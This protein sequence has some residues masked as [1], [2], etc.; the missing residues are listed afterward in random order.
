MTSRVVVA[1]AVSTLALPSV[2]GAALKDEQALAL[3]YAPAVELVAQAH[4]CG[5]GESYE[6]IDVD[7]LFDEPTV[8]L[9]GPWGGSDLVKIAPAASDLTGAR[10]EYHLDFPGNALHPGCDYERWARLITAGSSP[11]VYAHVA[12]DVHDPGKLALQYWFYYVFNDWNNTHEGDWEM[13]QLDFDAAT[14]HDALAV[15]PASVGYSQHEG[16]ERAAWDDPKLE[17]VGGTHPVVHPAAGSHANFYGEALYLGSSASE[18]VGC[19]DTRGPTFNIVPVVKTIPNDPAAAEKEFPWIAF[20]GRWGELQ[21][22]FFN[23]PTGPNLKEQWTEPFRWSA[24]WRDRSIAVPGGGAF[25]TGATDFFCSAVGAGSNGLRRSL[26]HPLPALLILAVLIALAV[27]VFTRTTWRPA[28]PLR[29]ARRRAWGQVLAA[30]ARMYAGRLW[31]FLG[32]GVLAVPISVAVTLLQAGLLGTSRFLGV[33]TQG[34]SGGVLVY[35]VL[36]IGTS[37]TLLGLG[38]VMAATAQAL[39]ELDQGRNVS[40]WRAYRL[41]LK[42][43]WPLLG[44]LVIATLVVSLFLTSVFLVPIAVWLAVRWALVVPAVAL[45]GRSALGALRRS[46]QL[47]RHGWFKVGSLIVV[48]AAIAI[49][50]GPVLG[51]LL[52]LLTNVSLAWLNVISGIVYAV[53]MPFVALATI[54]VYFDMRVWDELADEPSSKQLPAE[55]EFST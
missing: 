47:V 28:A 40:P 26:E 55:I 52:I 7:T 15:E 30:S 13:I 9:R 17:L 54:Y 29:L 11:T 46:R 39:V 42:F 16:A 10:Y 14:A 3:R 23:G 35:G 48:G 43:V 24:D 22:A 53:A 20:T 31:L 6:P 1:L 41:V 19:D 2:A 34:E 33:E 25:G 21:R 4:P 18:G 36:A 32:I 49:A 44:A 37:L 51:A 5:T 12:K 50:A 8:A 27:I 45:E 38:L